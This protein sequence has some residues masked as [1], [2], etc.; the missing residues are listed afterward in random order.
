MVNDFARVVS[1]ELQKAV[2]Q[3]SMGLVRGDAADYAKYRELCGFIRGL[4]S[5]QSL[6][7]DLA[8]RYDDNE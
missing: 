2:D 1:D 8:K 3:G 5:A 6:I 7:K 4:E